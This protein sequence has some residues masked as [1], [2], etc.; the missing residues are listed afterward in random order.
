MKKKL[1]VALPSTPMYVGFPLYDD[2]TLMDFCGATEVFA[3][4]PG[5]DAAFIPIWLAEEKRPIK[6]SEGTFVYPQYTFTEKHPHID[7]LFVPGGGAGGVT[8][9]MFSPAFQQFLKQTAK[10]AGW[11][12][13][14]C[15]GA[16][17]LA[18]A[19]L[20]KDCSATTYWSQVHNLSLLKKKFQLRIP[21][22]NP[23]GVIDAKRKIFTGG[24]I[25]SSL[26]LALM[27]IEKIKGKSYA[28]TSQ[29]YIQYAPNPPVHAGDPEQAPQ[30]LVD[31]LIQEGQDYDKMYY[32]AV[33]KILHQP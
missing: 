20:L 21:R 1:P 32:N 23:R 27:L 26:D 19:G 11:V 5:P 28:E 30:K 17:I 33:Q 16:F 7:I 15:V 31:K 22:G 13:S 25:S 6:T 8:N 18:A 3:F 14:V 12:G 9:A 2:V 24:G 29:L 4:P 10:N